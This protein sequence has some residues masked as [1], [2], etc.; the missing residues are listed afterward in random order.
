M[1]LPGAP[2]AQAWI[3]KARQYVAVHRALDEIETAALLGRN[4][5]PPS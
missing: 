2:H 1:R 4:E 5:P 3:Q